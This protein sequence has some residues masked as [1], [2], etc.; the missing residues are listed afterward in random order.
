MRGSG[1]VACALLREAVF[2]CQGVWAATIA[3]HC[4]HLFASPVNLILVQG[5]EVLLD[6]RIG[7]CGIVHE[8]LKRRK[9]AVIERPVIAVKRYPRQVVSTLDVMHTRRRPRAAGSA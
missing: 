2:T 4:T 1:R 8:D 7:A 9:L 5:G 6:C 3:E